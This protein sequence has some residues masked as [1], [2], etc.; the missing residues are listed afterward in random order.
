[1]LAFKTFRNSRPSFTKY[2]NYKKNT[3]KYNQARNSKQFILNNT[4]KTVVDLKQAFRRVNYQVGP[5]RAINKKFVKITKT[6]FL[7]TLA[8]KINNLTSKN[9]AKIP[10]IPIISN[11]LQN[12]NKK[13][14]RLL[15]SL[16]NHAVFIEP[17]RRFRIFCYKIQDKKKQQKNSGRKAFTHWRDLQSK[18]PETLFVK[19]LFKQQ[20]HLAAKHLSLRQK[21]RQLNLQNRSHI[22]PIFNSKYFWKSPRASLERR[23]PL[24]ERWER[25]NTMVK[26]QNTYK[27]RQK[28]YKKV[29]SFELR[30]A[31]LAHYYLRYARYTLFWSHETKYKVVNNF[32]SIDRKLLKYYSH[33]TEKFIY[34][35]FPYKRQKYPTNYYY[36]NYANYRYLFKNQTREQHTF[37]WLYR[38]TYKQLVKIFKKV[39]FFTKRKFEYIFYKHLELRL[40]TVVYRINMAF[41]L[42]QG[43]QWTEKKF[44]IVNSRIKHSPTYQVNIGDVI[45]PIKRLRYFEVPDQGW[46]FDIGILY[47]S[48]RLFWRPLQADQYPMHFIINE[49]I[50]AGIVFI[51]PVI[52]SIF[53]KRRWSVQYL[54]ISLLKFG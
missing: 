8:L 11:N 52:G 16:N 3:F 6:L 2:K 50:P 32:Y 48:T 15:K 17:Y 14:L 1:M 23:F 10:I 47:N 20:L 41:S 13:S 28:R 38:L 49:R 36:P 7:N 53:H 5:T 9:F 51:N 45:S 25:F 33:R 18:V 27:V 42:K 19:N 34:D 31:L 54:T 39:T 24:K 43:K 37:R 12:K 22:Y 26:I 40:D 21:A 44:F 35:R 46:T 30:N 29:I 4:T